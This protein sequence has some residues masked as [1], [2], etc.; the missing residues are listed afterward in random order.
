MNPKP[1]CIQCGKQFDSQELIENHLHKKHGGHSCQTSNSMIKFNV[2]CFGNP[3]TIG[4]W[5]PTFEMTPCKSEM[6]RSVQALWVMRH[7]SDTHC[8]RCLHDEKWSLKGLCD[9]RLCMIWGN[10]HQIRNMMGR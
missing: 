10:D 2:T 6:R 9:C 1:T 5:D 3:D 8:I 7:E 4:V